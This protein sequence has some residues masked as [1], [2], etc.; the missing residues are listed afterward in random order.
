MVRCGVGVGVGGG[1]GVGWKR[2]EGL[3][4]I[5]RFRITTQEAEIKLNEL[6]NQRQQIKQ[7]W[8]NLGDV[9]DCGE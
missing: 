1:G 6:V 8:R 5:C 2:G 7:Y 3:A 4:T 9:T